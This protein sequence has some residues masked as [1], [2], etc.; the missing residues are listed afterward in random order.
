MKTRRVICSR[1]IA[2]SIK[3]QCHHCG[4]FCLETVEWKETSEYDL[5]EFSDQ[6]VERIRRQ[7]IANPDVAA[8]CWEC[9]KFSPDFEKRYFKK[10]VRRFLQG[11]RTS[12]HARGVAITVLAFG[13]VF[14]FLFGEPTSRLIG[15][16]LMA[17]SPLVFI[18]IWWDASRY[19][20]KLNDIPDGVIDAIILSEYKS[21]L[22]RS[23]NRRE[24]RPFCHNWAVRHAEKLD[25]QSSSRL[26]T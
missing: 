20:K 7:L 9:H 13:A 12:T 26:G 3:K 10:G 21:F 19:A 6:T 17:T 15:L 25:G 11:A 8:Y 4:E 22:D 16:W 24:S 14:Y 1:R 5:G 18:A 2:I 23:L